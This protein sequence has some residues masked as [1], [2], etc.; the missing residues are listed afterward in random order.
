VHWAKKVI[1]QTT[2]IRPVEIH[3]TDIALISVFL[4]SVAVYRVVPL[5]FW[6]LP[7]AGLLIYAFLAIWYTPP[8]HR[9]PLLTLAASTVLFQLLVGFTV[10]FHDPNQQTWLRDDLSYLREA[11]AI[12]QAWRGG[13]FPELSLKGSLPYLGTLHTGYQRFVA[14]L[15]YV[16]GTDYRIPIFAN[17]LL[18]GCLPIAVYRAAFLLLSRL[19]RKAV[20]E[21]TLSRAPLFAALGI[22]LY[23]NLGYWASFLLKDA[24]LTVFVTC[25]LSAILEFLVSRRLAWVPLIIA[26]GFM[27]SIT[28]AYA[29]F[30][31]LAGCT[32]YVLA[33]APRKVVFGVCLAG[34]LL[35]IGLS[36]T[37]RGADYLSQLVHSLSVQL[38]SHLVTIPKAL[39]HVASAIPRLLLSPYGWVR[40]FGPSPA[41]ELYPG[42]WVMYLVIYPLGLVGLFTLAKH[43]VRIATVPLGMLVAASW[44]L[45]LAYGGDA[46]RQRLCL[47]PTWFIFAGT[48]RSIASAEKVLLAAWYTGFTLYVLVQLI[49]LPY[50]Y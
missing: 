8:P 18:L 42:M 1:Y 40:A 47:D 31:L 26:F 48:V 46:P 37:T 25:S 5:V 27:I 13:F 14:G 21:P 30:G 17:Y 3:K 35:L 33:I 28:R 24:L 45:I 12:A 4:L 39:A 23:P 34:I 2:A 20:P 32:L 44:V 9:R 10:G 15:F 43:D 22:A 36:Y 7:F 38:P 6:L 29:L 16:F 50:R 49:T 11:A 19:P 41:Y